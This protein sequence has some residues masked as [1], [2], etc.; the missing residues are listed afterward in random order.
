M[1][2]KPILIALLVL[3][4]FTLSIGGAV[5]QQPDEC[6]PKEGVDGEEISSVAG[7]SF[8][9]G[10]AVLFAGFCTPGGGG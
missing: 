8:G 6:A 1:R 2:L 7:P 4:A 10:T 9:Q 3:V 5:A